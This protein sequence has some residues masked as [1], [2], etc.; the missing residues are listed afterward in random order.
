MTDL[1]KVYTIDFETTG[2]DPKTAHAVEVAL[3]GSTVSIESYIKPP[4]PIPAETSAIHHIT[5]EDVANAE[6]WESVK[7]DLSDFLTGQAGE[8]LA[9][10][11]AHNAQYEKDILGEG[12]TPVLWV[13]TYK[14]ALRIWPDAPSHKNEVLRYWLELGNDRGRSAE[15]QRPHSAMHDAKVTYS[16]LQ[17]MLELHTIE[18]LIEW[19][20][21]P[22][23]LPYMPMGK[24]FKQK[25]DTIPAPYLD[26]CVKT[27]DLREDVKACAKAELDRRK[28]AYATQRSG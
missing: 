27:V 20:D 25:W 9:T 12:F 28:K 4:V 3:F 17:K 19:T 7:Q 2:V 21:E 13:C 15:V 22:A 1:S 23:A 11:V 26:W 16:L 5:D 24:H 8:H 14:C 10:L 6:T 18:Q